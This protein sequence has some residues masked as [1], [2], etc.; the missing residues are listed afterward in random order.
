[1]LTWTWPLDRHLLLGQATEQ[2][3]QLGVHLIGVLAVAREDAVAAL[4]VQLLVGAHVALE[5][6]EIGEPE[7][8]ADR[9][10]L[11]LDPRDL[12]QPDVMDLVG[13]QVGRGRVLDPRVVA[14]D[15]VG[16][17]PHADLAAALRDVRVAQIAGERAVARL[18]LILDRGEHVGADPVLIGLGDRRGQLL[19]RRRERAVLRLALGERLGLT[20]ALL[21]QDARRDEV[22]GRAELHQRDD[23]VE[24]RR[25]LAQAREI[26]V[27]VLGGR[28][29][30]ERYELRELD[31]QSAELIDRHQV[32]LEPRVV[33]PLL[34]VAH[35]ELLVEHFLV[36]E[37]GGVDRRE[38]GQ[39]LLGHR[40]VGGERLDRQIAPAIVVAAIAE[41]AG[42]LGRRPQGVLPLLVE[43]RGELLAALVEARRRGGRGRGGERRGG[44]DRRR[45]CG[46]GHRRWRRVGGR[47]LARAGRQ[48]D[49]DTETR[50]DEPLHGHLRG[51]RTIA[52]CAAT[53]PPANSLPGE[54][55]VGNATSRGRL[56][57]RA[58]VSRR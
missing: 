32:V 33:D 27:V 51:R 40:E 21:E 10:L 25:D 30:Q 18:D 52:R 24:R 16:Q 42:E 11:L 39:E 20:D 41:D 44:R 26:V 6:G 58:V 55:R 56:M 14:V 37:P 23:L 1:V 36:G 31:V 2:L 34:E 48:D 35:H 3:G 46:R 43:Q 54:P 22:L 13:G 49:A 53:R 29:R 12:G 7:L 19:E 4:G 28:E 50:T 17:R 57:R 5:R 9:G 15:A 8:V 45:R 38:P 47:R